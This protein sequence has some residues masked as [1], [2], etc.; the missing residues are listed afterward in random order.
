M[1]AESAASVSQ[2]ATTGGRTVRIRPTFRFRGFKWFFKKDRFS[3]YKYK[4]EDPSIQPASTAVV[5]RIID[6]GAVSVGIKYLK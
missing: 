5:R 6:I 4:W 1:E 3:V 2:K